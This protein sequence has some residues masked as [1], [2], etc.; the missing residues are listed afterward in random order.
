MQ[1]VSLTVPNKSET[2]W[3]MKYEK[4]VFFLPS[5]LQKKENLNFMA[6]DQFL[7]CSI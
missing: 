2:S 6:I 5:A 7:W 3:N 1:Q 4:I